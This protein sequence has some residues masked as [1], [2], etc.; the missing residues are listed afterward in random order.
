LHGRL[1]SWDDLRLV[2]HVNHLNLL[3]LG[4][5]VRA[6]RCL[7]EACGVLLLRGDIECL[8]KRLEL[9]NQIEVLIVLIGL[10]DD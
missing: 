10:G 8:E 2:Q 5:E 1:H 4:F 7:E 6:D 9:M 3:R